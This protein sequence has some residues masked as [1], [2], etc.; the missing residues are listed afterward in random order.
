MDKQSKKNY[1]A[2]IRTIK[3]FPKLMESEVRIYK[4]L[5]N[6]YQ[7]YAYFH[8]NGGSGSSQTKEN[9]KQCLLNAIFRFNR[10]LKKKKRNYLIWFKNQSLIRD[11]LD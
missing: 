3:K 10:P 9:Y 5:D 7:V 8:C 4:G 2:V 6:D 11:Y 1:R